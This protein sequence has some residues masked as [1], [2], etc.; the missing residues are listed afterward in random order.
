[1]IF[2]KDTLVACRFQFAL[3]AFVRVGDHLSFVVK[4]ATRIL[5]RGSR[6][7]TEAC[8]TS[9]LRRASVSNSVAT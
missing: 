9:I 4:I 7:T 8:L 5:R 6:S 3:G 1:M 2:G